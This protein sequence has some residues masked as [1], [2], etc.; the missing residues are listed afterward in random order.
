M[1]VHAAHRQRQRGCP[2]PAWRHHVM[3]RTGLTHT[4]GQRRGNARAAQRQQDT[5]RQLAVRRAGIAFSH[6][7]Q[8]A[9]PVHQPVQRQDRLVQHQRRNAPHG[10]RGGQSRQF[11]P[12]VMGKIVV[13]Y[14]RHGPRHALR[15]SHRRNPSQVMVHQRHV[16]P[17]P[18]REGQSQRRQR[19]SGDVPPGLATAGQQPHRHPA[20][21]E[22]IGEQPMLAPQGGVAGEDRAIQRRGHAQ[23]ARR[24]HVP[25]PAAQGARRGEGI[26][27]GQ[28]RRHRRRWPMRR[29]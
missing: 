22:P 23:R 24:Q 25:L 20:M 10:P 5:R 8:A 13:P 19:H 12:Q 21:C 17:A 15:R 29:G 26:E 6:P 9:G 1:A 18:G 27:F 7:A 2:G 16:V 4:R 28:Q 14:H 11:V 3:R